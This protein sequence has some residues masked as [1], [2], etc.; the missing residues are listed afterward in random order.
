MMTGAVPTPPPLY[1]PPLVRAVSQPSVVNAGPFLHAISESIPGC[2]EYTVNVHDTNYGQ[3]RG[4][5]TLSGRP[6]WR[7]IVGSNV[8][9]CSKD[10][11][12]DERN[13]PWVWVQFKSQEEPWDHEGYMSFRILQPFV[14]PPVVVAP[15]APPPAPPPVQQTQQNQQDTTTSHPEQTSP[16]L[17]QTTTPKVFGKGDLPFIHSEYKANQAR[18]FKEFKRRFFEATL[19]IESVR[20]S[21]HRGWLQRLIQGKTERLPPRGLLYGGAFV[22][23]PAVKERGGFGP[24][25][26]DNRRSLIRVCDTARLPAVGCECTTRAA[27][28]I[29]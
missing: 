10:I 12:T 8:T 16:E 29:V 20:E 18:W 24:R 11:V 23:F 6:L 27:F 2:A 19:S 13:I 14:P 28:R 17:E 5:P 22:R 9:I 26:G 15:P 25:A 3:V 1:G 21:D 4:K 7:L